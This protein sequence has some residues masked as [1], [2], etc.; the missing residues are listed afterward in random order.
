MK[1]Q[2]QKNALKKKTPKEEKE[3]LSAGIQKPG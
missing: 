2:S 3:N 1:G